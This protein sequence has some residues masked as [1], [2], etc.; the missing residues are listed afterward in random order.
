M[1]WNLVAEEEPTF[2]EQESD[3]KI[4]M[5]LKVTFGRYLIDVSSTSCTYRC[6]LKD[7]RFECGIDLWDA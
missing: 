1:R 5:L 7:T 6:E 3:R 4:A 2:R